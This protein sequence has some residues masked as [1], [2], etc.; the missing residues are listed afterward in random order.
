MALQIANVPR[1]VSPNKGPFFT[2]VDIH[3]IKYAHVCLH[4][5]LSWIR[6]HKY[7]QGGGMEGKRD[8]DTQV[9]PLS[10]LRQHIHTFMM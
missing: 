4:S 10:T 5:W 8:P 3:S 1:S 6:V 7:S 9:I 2:P